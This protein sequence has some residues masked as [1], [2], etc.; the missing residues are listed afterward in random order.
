MKNIKSTK[1]GFAVR[2]GIR[3]KKAKR[4]STLADLKISSGLK[5]LSENI[6][7]YIYKM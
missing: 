2:K 4:L 6:D 3:K 7:K 1:L 5:N